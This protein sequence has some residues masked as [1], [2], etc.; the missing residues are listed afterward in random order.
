MQ[1]IEGRTLATVIQDLRRN[2][3]GR[4]TNDERMTKDQYPNDQGPDANAQTNVR[5][6][7]LDILSSLD[8]GHST[9]FRT[10]ARLGVEA[11]QA[12]EH[13]HQLGV[14]HRDIKPANLLVDDRGKLWITDF[15]LAHCQGQEGPTMS[16]DLLGTLRY[17]SPEQALGKRGQIDHRTDIYALGMTLYELLTLEPAFTGGDREELLQQIAFEEPC[18]PRRR[19]RALP[20]ELETIVLKA[21]AKPPDERYATAQALADDLERF[22]DDKPIRAK[23]PTLFQ[24]LQKWSRRHKPVVVTAVLA[25]VGFLVMAVVV[26][27]ISN[28]LVTRAKTQ[29]DEA[30]QAETEA[31]AELTQTLARERQNLYFQRIARADLEWWNNYVGRADQILDECP[32]EYRHWEWGYLKGLCHAALATF[33]GHRDGV[34]GVAYS[35]D[36]RRLASASSDQTVK[37]WDL[38]TVKEILTLQGKSPF[39]CVAFSGDGRLL[40]SGSGSWPE[41]QPGEVRVWDATTGHELLNLTGHKYAVAGV[42]FSPNGQQLASAGWDGTVRLWDMATGREIRTLRGH[43]DAVKCI[44]FS[45]VGQHLASGDHNGIVIIWDTVSG[46]RLH[47]LRGHTADVLGVAFSPDGQRLASGSW[48]QTVKVWDVAKGQEILPPAQ[49]AEIVWGVA[50][51]PDGQRLASACSDASVKIWDARSH[52]EL[53][54]FR[55][56]RGRV[57]TVAF[58]PGGRCLASASFDHAIKVWDLTSEQQGPSFPAQAARFPLALSPDGRRVALSALASLNRSIAARLSVYEVQG[59]RETLVLGERPGG[60]HSAAFSP[61]GQRLAADWDTTVK[62]WESKT[63]REVFTLAGHSGPIT[64]VTFSPDSRRLASASED[65]TVRVWDAQSGQ[66]FLV[67]AGHAGPVTSVAFSPDGH[68]LASTSKDRTVKIWDVTTAKELLTLTGHD[69]PITDAVFSPTGKHVTSASEDRTV[70]VWDITTGRQVLSLAGHAD[71]VNAVAFSP[72][73]QRLVSASEDGSVR[74]WEAA[75]GQEALTLRRHLARASGVAFSP[76]GERL[77]VSG[78][79][80]GGLTGFRFFETVEGSRDRRAALDEVFEADA[81]NARLLR[82]DVHSRLRHWDKAIEAYSEAIDLGFSAAD[83]WFARGTAYGMLARYE[84]AA[85]DFARAV[86]TKPDDAVLWYLHAMAKLGAGDREGYLRV[87]AGMQQQFRETKHPPSAAR[88]VF[89]CAPV[90]EAAAD[91]TEMVRLGKLAVGYGRA[92]ASAFYR[93]GQ[94]EAAIRCYRG[95]EGK[96]PPFSAVEMLFLAMAQHR[97][98][99][100]DDARETFAAAVK[101]IENTERAVAAGGSWDWGQ[102]VE[103]RYLRKETESLLN[104]K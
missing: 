11:A 96:P 33:R 38:A 29:T 84:S 35:P 25:L 70:R 52:K 46:R 95:E 12:L 90:A 1:F 69:A 23:R 77:V 21:T 17:M 63:G 22:L 13:A 4:R 73:G 48:D 67:L 3:E 82:G 8:L 68:S 28:Q 18:P 65:K 98:G 2:V 39:N 71:I 7:T 49:H 14:I 10:A 6:S 54:T 83:A 93:D 75:T 50:F 62:I 9:F 57:Y 34:R 58:S 51:S 30:L 26:L 99:R 87:C 66:E 74:I 42:A 91:T 36:G 89:T 102:Q 78:V 55:G 27:A 104:G 59:G 41:W 47:A 94:Y 53:A 45:P 19:N 15:G 97:L 44:A 76:D 37:I 43:T 86:E 101:W 100:K 61:D 56:H 32:P 40:A 24:R 20:T 16:G 31:R 64:R 80:N 81:Q 72:D 60:F 103:I 79:L 5:Y 85:A 92:M 88:V